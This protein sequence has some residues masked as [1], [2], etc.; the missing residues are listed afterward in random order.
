MSR[1]IKLRA[2]WMNEAAAARLLEQI[3]AF[4][5]KWRSDTLGRKLNLAGTE[6]RALRLRTLAPV[7]M[8]RQERVAFSQALARQRRQ[9]R[10]R[11]QGKK[12]RAEYL[13]TSL[14]QTKPWLAFNIS[15][16][17]WY[18]RGKPTHPTSGTSVD[19]IKIPKATTRPV[20]R[21]T[22][23]VGEDGWPSGTAP[24]RTAEA[25]SLQFRVKLELEHHACVTRLVP[26]QG[27]D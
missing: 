4:P 18:R 10:R 27:F 12:P 19:T 2:A 5:Q 6:W 1:I 13:A 25:R 16:S 15:R 17:T 20:P 23:T 21:S 8:T 24:S 22:G 14:S 3:E 26:R 7:D 11:A 9:A